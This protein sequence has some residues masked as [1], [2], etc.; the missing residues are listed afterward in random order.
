MKDRIMNLSGWASPVRRRGPL[1]YVFACALLSPAVA[2][3]DA[4]NP[5][6][7]SAHRAHHQQHSSSGAAYRRSQSA[8]VIPVVR[9][10]DHNGALTDSATVLASD[11]PAIVDFVYTSCTVV[12]P[13]LSQ[14]FAR[15]QAQ[16]DAEKAPA[17]LI[18]LSIDPEQD[19]PA[20][21]HDYAQKHGAGSR[22]RFYTGDPAAMTA[23]QRAFDTLRGN[24]MSHEPVVFLRANARTPWVRLE[25]FATAAE[26]MGEYRRLASQ[27][28][29]AP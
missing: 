16:L 19:T 14:T 22:W 5:G 26:I 21:L 24:K 15:V 1:A 20:V 13:V 27:S 29:Q 2:G 11:A 28:V 9:I 25:G 23:L 17:H 18:S 8:Y 3:A 6:G 12:C 4:E 7:Q 10:T